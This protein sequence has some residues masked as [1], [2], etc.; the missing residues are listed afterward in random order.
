MFLLSIKISPSLASYW[1]VNKFKI[2]D[3]PLPT[4]PVIPN[5]CPLFNWNEIFLMLLFDFLG[6]QN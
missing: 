6:K 2:L 3:L 4:N 5:V 1:R